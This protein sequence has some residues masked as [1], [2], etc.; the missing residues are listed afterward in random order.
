[1]LCSNVVGIVA[2]SLSFVLILTGLLTDYWLVDFGSG[3]SHQGL[4]QI[5]SKNNCIKIPGVEYI[6]AARGL[7]IVSMAFLLFGTLSSCLAFTSFTVGKITA[8]LMAG[9]MEFISAI[10]LIIGMSVYTG[11][12]EYYVNNNSYNYG[13]S[14]FLGWV[15]VL[16]LLTAALSHLHA[17]KSSPVPGYE[18]V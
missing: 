3:L 7:L 9:I 4:W 16:S 15:A 6:G 5:C 12:T 11:E 18:S 2:S 1:M 10:F 14:F 13:W 17:H 8:P